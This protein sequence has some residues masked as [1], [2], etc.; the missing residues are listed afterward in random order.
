MDMSGRVGRSEFW[1][2]VLANFAIAVLAAILQSIMIL[3]LLAVYNLAMILPAA[4]MGARR[5]QDTGR[6]GRLVWVFIIAGFASQLL[7][8][9]A[10]MS[11]YAL[12]FL[13]FLFFGPLVLVI[14]MAFLL[15]CIVLVYFWCQPGDPAANVYGPPPLRFD[16][17]VRVSPSP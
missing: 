1:Y 9:M 12:G 16:P 17:S 14:N 4:G 13:S 7:A 3:P 2:F 11:S 8:A 10:V 15:A 5:L 6:D